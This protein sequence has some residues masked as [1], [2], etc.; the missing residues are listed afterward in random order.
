MAEYR[1][2]EEDRALEEQATRIGRV[3][4]EAV[5]DGASVL[6]AMTLGEPQGVIELWVDR[7]YDGLRDGLVDG[8]PQIED[9]PLLRPQEDRL[10]AIV[11]LLDGRIRTAAERVLCGVDDA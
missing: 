7:L 5:T 8:L 3:L 11:L 10:A 1:T 2:P 9:C 6:V 4:A